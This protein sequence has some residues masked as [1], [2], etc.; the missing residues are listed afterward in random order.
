LVAASRQPVQPGWTFKRSTLSS[1]SG[2]WLSA[3]MAMG[4]LNMNKGIVGCALGAVLLATAGGLSPASAEGALA[5][6]MTSSV[7]KD[8]VA[9]GT[10]INYKSEEEARK[11]AIDYCHKFKGAPKA[12]AQCRVVGTFKDKCYAI[13]MDPKAG[14]PG[15]GWS[16][17]AI[18]SDAEDHAVTN[19]KATAGSDRRQFCV[20]QELKCDGGKS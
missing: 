20:V 2:A 16:I 7:S 5:V 17:A 12:S 14:T 13:S 9:F 6:G 4:A 11:A 1:L 18:K 10:A 8:G 15:A 19:C 3:R